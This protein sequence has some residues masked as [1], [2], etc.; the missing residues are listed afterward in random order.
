MI[1]YGLVGRHRLLV[2]SQI[3][4]S[5]L[6]YFIYLLRFF[7]VAKVILVWNSFSNP[8]NVWLNE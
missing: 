1:T 3:E 4:N 7:R 2:V 6:F 5:S 8:I